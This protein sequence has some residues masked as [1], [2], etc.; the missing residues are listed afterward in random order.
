MG[1]HHYS[2]ERRSMVVET[3]ML[4]TLQN[5]SF[6]SHSRGSF[7]FRPR[8]INLRLPP[9]NHHLHIRRQR[10]LTL[11]Q[12]RLRRL[13]I[14]QLEIVLQQQERKYDLDLIRG[15][16]AARACVF[17][18]SE[19]HEIGVDGGEGLIL[20]QVAAEVEFLRVG[21]QRWVHGV[22]LEDLDEGAGGEVGA[23]G[24]GC[25]SDYEAADGG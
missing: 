14:H 5:R 8:H 2:N 22:V 19:H 16:E 18:V 11:E 20:V 3:P 6:L 24:E 12:K 15:E 7:P 9:P 4:F 23:V 25:G 21:V 13:P 10:K 1:I 17:P